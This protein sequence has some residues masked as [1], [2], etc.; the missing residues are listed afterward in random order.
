MGAFFSL[1]H[2]GLINESYIP[3]LE[4]LNLTYSIMNQVAVNIANVFDEKKQISKI[5][6]RIL[7]NIIN[8]RSH[9]FVFPLIYNQSF[10]AGDG[11]SGLTIDNDWKQVMKL[12]DIYNK[13]LISIKGTH[14]FKYIE[15]YETLYSYCFNV[16]KNPQIK[17]PLLSKESV[18]AI[19]Q[20]VRENDYE[21][22]KDFYEYR[23][24]EIRNDR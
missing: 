14:Y 20:F 23:G 11:W 17:N 24:G 18:Q 22:F 21:L 5:I 7:R 2:N 8:L 6:Q 9:R 10:L 16:N 1:Q 12:I 13:H 15:P 4:E 19:F 3:A